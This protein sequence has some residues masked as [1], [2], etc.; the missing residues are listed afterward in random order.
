MRPDP[1]ALPEIR[2]NRICVI[3]NVSGIGGMVSFKYK[4]LEGLAK[5]GISVS[6]DLKDI[7]YQSVLIIGGTRQLWGLWVARQRG[8]RLVQRLNGMNWLHRL[9][10]PEH[11]KASLRHRLRAESGN[12]L[13]SFIRAR[14]AD[15][16]VY[17]SQF[18]RSWWARVYGPTRVTNRVVYN[19]VDLQA[20]SPEGPGHPPSD[21]WRIL[22]VEGSLMGG[23]EAGLAAAVG[24]AERLADYQPVSFA[25]PVELM[26]V[27]RVAPAVQQ[28]WEHKT[29]LTIHWAGQVERQRIPEID[30]SAHLLYS[31]DINAACPNSV[32]EALA[33]GLPVAAFDTGALPELV[34]GD[35]GRVA[36]YG[37]DPWKLD[38]PDLDSLAQGVAD[39]LVDQAHFRIEARRRAEAMFSLAGM[40]AGYLA[41]LLEEYGK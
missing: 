26:V 28:A 40:V 36:P 6:Q 5:H 30:R 31:S 37:G 20:Y 23:Y 27:G 2:E 8:A 24:L 19:G 12:M 10:S 34:A 33:C 9:S 29:K 18:S 39:I 16:I 13:L 14:L 38:P 35:A 21:R 41:A 25:R 3:P 11:P 32:I 7:P 15:G 22:L 17:Q 4:L 1:A